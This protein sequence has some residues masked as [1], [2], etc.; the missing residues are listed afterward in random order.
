MG[1]AIIE[2]MM[3]PKRPRTRRDIW[4]PHAPTEKCDRFGV[5]GTRFHNS[6]AARGYHTYISSKTGSFLAHDSF[7]DSSFTILREH[8]EPDISRRALGRCEHAIAS[9]T[10]LYIVM[11]KRCKTAVAVPG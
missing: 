5:R 6:A 9:M 4:Y 2:A 1:K 8:A 3:C 7:N 11:P 10:A